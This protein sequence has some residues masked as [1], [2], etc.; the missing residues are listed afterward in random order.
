MHLYIM[1]HG[2]AF[3]RHE[4]D[5]ADAERPLTDKGAR[6]VH[7][8][9]VALVRILPRPAAIL[10]SPLV[11]AR[12]TA[13]IVGKAWGRIK[14][15]EIAALTTGD[16]TEICRALD[17]YAPDDTVVL[18]GHE[19][20]ISIVTARLL[21]SKIALAFA[22]RKAGVALLDVESPRSRRGKL[23]WFIPPAVLRK[24]QRRA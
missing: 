3:E 20:W 12:A 4:W 15:T 10:T 16:W 2:I 19:E 6:R 17:R 21:G 8:V 23:V 13:E 5:G 11:R 18:V 24:L 7:D 9:A 22:F 1:R 14:P